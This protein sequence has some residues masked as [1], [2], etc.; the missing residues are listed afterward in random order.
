MG[1]LCTYIP[2]KIYRNTVEQ[3]GWGSPP[4]HGIPRVPSEPTT[5]KGVARIAMHP[6]GGAA[7]RRGDTT[8]ERTNQTKM[9]C[10]IG[11]LRT[12]V[13]YA[14]GARAAPPTGGTRL[15]V[16]NLLISYVTY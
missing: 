11:K 5:A 16:H 13:H 15:H 14:S 6:N 10:I 8:N 3:E 9:Y 1:S 2:P 4:W 12:A 7:L